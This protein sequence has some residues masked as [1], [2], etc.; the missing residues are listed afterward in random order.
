MVV[1]AYVTNIYGAKVLPYW[2]NAFF[3]LHIL[4]YFAYI[5]PIWVSAPI[6]SHSQVWT[7]FRNE[8]GWSSTGL[9]VLVGQLTGISEQVGIDT[10]AHMSEE[11]KNASRTIPKTILIVYVLNFVLLFP[12]LLTICYHMPNLD[13]ALADT[14][15][16]PAIYVRTARLLRDLA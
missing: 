11:V 9:A 4:V 13:D 7:E 5:V 6:A 8:G 15:T 2:Q 16:Y 3:V 12:A 1:I 14:T 10:T